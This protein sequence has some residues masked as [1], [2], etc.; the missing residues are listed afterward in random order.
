MILRVELRIVVDDS[1]DVYKDAI[2]RLLIEIPLS[3][4]MIFIYLLEDSFKNNLE[5]LMLVHAIVVLAATVSE[6]HERDSKELKEALNV[7][8]NETV[9]GSLS[10]TILKE[11]SFLDSKL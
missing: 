5:E 3:L 4:F 8:V 7:S 9:I 10:N 1:Q 6:H 11:K 2:V